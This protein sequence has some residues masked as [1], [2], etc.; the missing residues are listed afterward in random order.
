M[1]K[2]P[3]HLRYAVPNGYGQLTRMAVFVLADAV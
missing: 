1:Q 2:A 3:P